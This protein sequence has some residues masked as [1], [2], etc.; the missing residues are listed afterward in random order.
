MMQYEVVGYAPKSL[1]SIRNYPWSGRKL[2]DGIAQ[3]LLGGD[4]LFRG[5]RRSDQVV[6]P[7]DQPLLGIST[8]GPMVFIMW[9]GMPETSLRLDALDFPGCHRFQVSVFPASDG[10]D[11]R[12]NAPTGEVLRHVNVSG[13]VVVTDEGDAGLLDVDG[14]TD[15]SP[16]PVW[17]NRLPAKVTRNL[18][19]GASES[20]VKMYDGRRYVQTTDKDVLER[21]RIVHYD[22]DGRTWVAID[23][24]GPINTLLDPLA[25]VS[26]EVDT[27]KLADQVLKAWFNFSMSDSWD[28]YAVNCYA[29]PDQP[30]LQDLAVAIRTI[31]QDPATFFGLLA[32][33]TYDTADKLIQRH[34]GVD[35]MVSED[36]LREPLLTLLPRKPI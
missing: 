36:L 29:W 3:Q 12:W 20:E 17:E 1:R 31:Q 33:A 8:W 34:Y 18:L 25:A 19:A 4:P 2:A 14:E 10:V 11:A 15:T 27:D 22:D 7:Q 24:T 13:G 35:H 9:S 26:E 30:E 16:V 6:G 21:A 28:G 23:Q 5:E 32:T